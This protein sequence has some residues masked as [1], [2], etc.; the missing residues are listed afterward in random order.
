MAIYGVETRGFGPRIGFDGLPQALSE[1]GILFVAAGQTAGTEH[2]L[3]TET[4]REAV[5][6]F[7]A[8]GG[9]I[10]FGCGTWTGD[11]ARTFLRS[12]GVGAPDVSEGGFKYWIPNP[13]SKSPL[14]ETP[15]AQT[16]EA[17]HTRTY[18]KDW[19]ADLEPLL[20]EKSAPDESGLLVANDVAGAGTILFSTTSGEW[21]TR[22]RGLEVLIGNIFVHAFGTMPAPGRTFPLDDVYQRRDPVA[23]TTHLV[24]A[25]EAEWH[26]AD[27]PRRKAFLVSEPIGMRRRFAYVEIAWP[28]PADLRE[29]PVRAF[30]AN[31]VE[32]HAQRL[33]PDRIALTTFLRAYDDRLVYVYAAGK[34]TPAV[35]DQTICS[36]ARTGQGWLF[37]N[38]QFDAVLALERPWLRQIRAHGGSFNALMT[39]G[40]SER[41]LGEGTRFFVNKDD[42]WAASKAEL[43]AAGPVVHTVR[44]TVS[45]VAGER[46]VDVSLVRGAR[47]LFFEGRADEPHAIRTDTG[48]C[49]GGSFAHNAL[50]YE[51]KQGMKRL[52]LIHNPASHYRLGAYAAEPW[53]AVVDD[54][55][56]EAGGAF[57]E[58][59][60]NA[61]LP[62]SIYSSRENG[63][64]VQ[65]AFAV[66]PRGARGGWVASMGGARAVRGAFLEWANAPVVTEGPEQT[67]DHRVEPGTAVFGRDFLRVHGP[68]PY[69]VMRSGPG[70]ED[71]RVDDRAERAVAAVVKEVA[72]NVVLMWGHQLAPEQLAAVM[73]AAGRRGLAVCLSIHT[74]G[75]GDSFS[76]REAYLERARRLAAY[77]ADLYWILNEYAHGEYNEACAADFKRKT[78]F[79]MVPRIDLS[80]RPD[81]ATSQTILWHMNA[82]TELAR[83]MDA[84]VKRERPDALTFTVSNTAGMGWEM[85]GYNDLQAWSDFVGTLSGD[86]YL[87]YYFRARFGIQFIRGAQGND[88]PVLTVHGWPTSAEGNYRNMGQHLMNGSNGLWFFYILFQRFGREVMD[89]V[90]REYEVLRDT[91]LGDVLA[92]ARPVRYAAVLYDQETFF[93]DVKRGRFTGLRPVYHAYVEKQAALRNVPMDVVYTKHLAA[94]LPGYNVLIVPSGRGMSDQTV[95]TIRS[96]VARGGRVIAEGEALLTRSL[97]ALC[98]VR[99]GE[100]TQDAVAIVPAPANVLREDGGRPVVT[101]HAV[102][103]G[104][105]VAV[106]RKDVDHELLRPLLTDLAGALPVDIDP[107][108][109]PDVRVA[110]LSD[111]RR[112]AIG[113]YNEQPEPRRVTVD[114]GSLLPRQDRIVTNVHRGTREPA[115][116]AVTVDVPAGAWLFLLLESADAAPPLAPPGDPV[117]AGVY[118]GYGPRASPR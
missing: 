69:Y 48:W 37:R 92:A 114:L 70:T 9:V 101:A 90:V 7:L 42:Q 34:G 11:R 46:I 39:W 36:S 74:H 30:G 16:E 99:A 98:G 33:G 40:H 63:Q 108:S 89:P 60:A 113:L 24:K 22:R 109:A 105:A 110:A 72:G 12:S 15:G 71:E 13:A 49:P 4:S 61:V 95:G 84:V 115:N 87:E 50:W 19:P 82:T 96:W 103:E 52:P 88:K 94:E 5:R 2:L 51:A 66:T 27:A 58:P 38:D 106:A 81:E 86:F 102:G 118:S 80:K 67:Q 59:G 14:L 35:H 111:G 75:L 78:G 43:V 56:G 17:G 55:T 25:G 23:N 79:E 104:T 53:Y 44:Y 85:P 91:G 117:A 54:E 65:Q 93:A 47:A 73:K 100:G 31:G 112:T 45:D 3:A 62:I 21:S 1:A 68:F 29:A 28:L 10:W 77:K 107:A 116:D 64:E 8:R 83:Q 18:M 76:N 6:A 57:R 41:W 32:L 97:A 26:V 20:L